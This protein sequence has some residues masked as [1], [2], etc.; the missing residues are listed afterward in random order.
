M[1]KL[2]V[3][4]NTE[5]ARNLSE[6]LEDHIVYETSENGI[7]KLVAYIPDDAVDDLLTELHK[8]IDLRYKKNIIEVSSPNFV[9][10]SVLSK[11]DKNKNEEDK[12]PVEQLLEHANTYYHFDR[13]KMALI[14]IASIIALVGLF[15]NNVTIVIGAMLLAPFIGPIYAFTINTAVGKG[16][17]AVRNLSQIGLYISISFLISMLSTLVLETRFDLSLTHEIML[18]L[19]TNPV[20]IVMAVM[21]GLAAVISFSKSISEGLAGVAIAAAILPP[22]VTAGIMVAI[23][24]HEAI[25]AII[26]TFQNV[27]GLMAGG[28]IATMVL[29]IVPRRDRERTFARKMLAR[30]LIALVIMIVVLAVVA[31]SFT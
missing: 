23:V 21:L 6:V 29:D 15:Q 11:A 25:N 1:K 3:R 10:S 26:L 18:R 16:K 24:P 22:A 20:Y 13:D 2:T 5:K 19:D 30:M 9:V 7:V 28:L 4:V 14:A 8:R 31:V 17:C 12:T 27:I